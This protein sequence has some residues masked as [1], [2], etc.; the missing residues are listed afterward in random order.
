MRGLVVE[1]AWVDDPHD[2]KEGV[3]KFFQERFRET[4]ENK[5]KLD[6]VE[7]KKLVVEDNILLLATFEECEV[8]TVVWECGDSKS[9][10]PDGFNF[11]LIKG[12]WKLIKEDVLRFLQEYHAHGKFPRGCN[13]SF[14]T[15]IPKVLDPQNLGKFRPIFLVGCMYKILAKVLSNRLKR[16]LGEDIDK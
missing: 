5:P 6:E 13:S 7:F 4:E 15:L 10:G 1:G 12:F 9:P 14:I 3:E 2:V 16:T 11:K 8:K